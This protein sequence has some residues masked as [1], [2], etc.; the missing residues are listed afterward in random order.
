MK[1]LYIQLSQFHEH[2][3]DADRIPVIIAAIFITI[4]VGMVSGPLRGNA[5]PFF[6]QFYELLFGTIGDRLYNTRRSRSDLAFRSLI[7]TVFALF[8]AFMLG[9]I[10]SRLT[11]GLGGYGTAL[12]IILLSL[13]I[14]SGAVWFILLRLYFVLDKDGSAKGGFYGISRSTRVN[15]IGLDDYGI[16]RVAMGYVAYSFDKGLVAPC[17]W[18]LL[19]GLPVLFIY[20]VLAFLAWRFGKCGFSKGFGSVPLAL[21]KLMGY[22]PSLLSGF[23]FMAAAAVTP[24][25]SL[26][27]SLL[28]WWDIRNK[29]PYEQGGITLCSIAWPLNISLGGPVVDIS[30]SAINNKWIGSDNASAKI[31]YKHLRRG[32]YINVIAHLLFLASLGSVYIYA[33]KFFNF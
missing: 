3:I 10:F 24:T 17:F 23:L 2:I 16:T 9:R 15:L 30:G 20:T 1:N 8:F 5:N 7:I 4:V 21:E 14:T 11:H 31:D 22:V 18:Y 6:W 19:G 28:M 29:A 32:I 25:A 26:R 13:S 12:E 27:K 33:G